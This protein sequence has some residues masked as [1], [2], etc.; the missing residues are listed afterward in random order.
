MFHAQD[1]LH[2]LIGLRFGHP[3]YLF[4]QIGSTN[5]QARR[6]ADADAP[7]GLLV[8]AEEQTAG[9]GRANRRWLTPP[10]TALALSLVLRPPLSAGLAAR[11][12]MLAGLAV[13]EAAE[14]VAGLRA[15]LKWPNDVLIGGRKVAGILVESAFRGDALEYA[16][17]GL[18]INVS[19]APEPGTVDFPA[20]SLEAEAGRPV[21]R[22]NLLRAVLG[23]LEARYEGLAGEQLFADW[24]ARLA[25]L[26]EPVELL[27]EA[28]T[29][30]GIAE[31][32]APDG[33]LIIRTAAG[34]RQHV[35]AGEVRL[36]PA[37]AD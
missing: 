6:L 35:L 34:A 29:L 11:V 15:D 37:R 10:G 1:L 5:D 22:L 32:V 3:I 14:R 16:V 2:R 9:R 17:V 23:A 36:R 18:G 24:R 33:A 13:C 20:T 25:L 27:T 28:G 4:Q 7:E 8:V 21:D 12:T 30:A 26:G 19:W 31:D